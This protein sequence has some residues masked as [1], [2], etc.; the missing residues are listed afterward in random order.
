ME[1][2]QKTPVTVLTG[3]L[4]AG[5]TTLV[6]ELLTNVQGRRLAIIVNEFGDA[7]VDGDVL[8]DC[9]VP[10]CPVDN[11]VELANGCICCTVAKDFVPTVNALLEMEPRPEHIV[12]ET[13]GLALPKPLLKAFE[14]PTIRSKITIDGVITLADAEAVSAGRFATNVEAVQAQREADENVSHETPLAEVFEDQ[15]A[16]ADLVLLTKTDLVD[17]DAI[18][19]A[20]KKIE[21]ASPREVRVLEISR[22]QIDPM[23]V[24][25]L[26]AAAENDLDARPSHHDG[27][28]DHDHDDF[29]SVVFEVGEVRDRDRFVAHLSSLA[30]RHRVLR[31]KGYVAVEGKPRKLLIQGVGSRMEK[32]FGPA[33]EQSARA[34]RLVFI[35]EHDALDVEAIRAALASE[36]GA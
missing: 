5:K 28:D 16:C 8:K 10:D 6:R 17:R 14:W 15:V 23:V 2:L 31:I 22:G 20:R 32:S 33:W 30:E 21:E 1:N 26:D 29:E 3:F 25:G 11:I 34:G 36:P 7:G 4:G 24:L 18:D 19:L 9:A 35:A 27:E 12:V 13:S